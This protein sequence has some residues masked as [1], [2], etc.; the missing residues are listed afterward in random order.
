MSTMRTE[1]NGRNFGILT[2]LIL[3]CL[4]YLSAAPAYALLRSVLV[5]LAMV[6]VFIAVTQGR[7]FEWIAGRWIAFGELLGRFTSPILLGSIYYVL[8]TPIALW[9]Q[10][11]SR[12][13]LHLK[14]NGLDTAWQPKENNDKETNINFD[15]QY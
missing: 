10:A 13:Q 14:S 1:K 3:G 6:C 15:L 4:A 8:I 7:R 5:F 12:D 11:C 2:A 9:F